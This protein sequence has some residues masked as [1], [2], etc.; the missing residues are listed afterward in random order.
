[1]LPPEL[2]GRTFRHELTGA[3]ARADVA[4]G[5]EWLFAGQVFDATSGRDLSE[6]VVQSAV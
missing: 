4:A 1:M 6:T 5:E 2:H 3:D